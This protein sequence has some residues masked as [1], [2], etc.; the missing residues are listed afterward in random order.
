MEFGGGFWPMC[1]F[2]RDIGLAAAA[3]E[4]STAR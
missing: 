2:V 1:N 4:A 3:G